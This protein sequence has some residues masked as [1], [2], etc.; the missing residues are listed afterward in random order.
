MRGRVVPAGETCRQ[1]GQGR[2]SLCAVPY[3]LDVQLV[4]APPV[5]NVREAYE[6]IE[7]RTQDEGLPT[8]DVV[9]LARQL[10]VLHHGFLTDPEDSRNLTS[11]LSPRRPED[12]F[13]LTFAQ[14]RSLSAWTKEAGQA[15]RT[16]EREGP[17]HF[18][19]MQH[20]FGI[21]GNRPGYEGA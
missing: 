21:C 16:R 17:D 10:E 3:L 19:H 2:L 20:G 13:A 12:A 8:M 18:G 15:S 6:A 11:G 9:P 4:L 5:E 14:C 7:Q 1:A